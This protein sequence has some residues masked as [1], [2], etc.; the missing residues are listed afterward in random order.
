LLD[1]LRAGSR[2]QDAIERLVLLATTE[3]ELAEVSLDDS[4][5]RRESPQVLGKSSAR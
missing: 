3:R 2:K 1:A 5:D 4:L